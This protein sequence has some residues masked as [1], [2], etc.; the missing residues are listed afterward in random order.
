[1]PRLVPNT[2]N[3]DKWHKLIKASREG[4]VTSQIGYGKNRAKWIPVNAVK[5]PVQVISPTQAVVERAVAQIK[6]QNEEPKH[7]LPVYK[8]KRAVSPSLSSEAPTKK[9]GKSLTT[10]KKKAS[11]TQEKVHYQIWPS[12]K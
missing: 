11:K 7:P 4:R 5:D 2:D 12:T 8:G 6:R 10:R 1:M 9:V 3:A